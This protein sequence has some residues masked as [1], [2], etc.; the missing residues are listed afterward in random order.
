MILLVEF[1][2]I[3]EH[4]GRFLPIIGMSRGDMPC[5]SAGHCV[6]RREAVPKV[7]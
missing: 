3:V 2:V 5:F 7:M 1:K 6:D 4:G